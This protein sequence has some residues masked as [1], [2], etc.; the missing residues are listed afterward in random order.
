MA[1]QSDTANVAMGGIG[2][3]VITIIYLVQLAAMVGGFVEWTGSIFL[4][5]LLSIIL[6]FIPI[7]GTIAVIYYATTIWD[8]NV[9]LAI[10]FF[11]FPLALSIFSGSLAVLLALPALIWDYIKKIFK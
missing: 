5:V 6:D 2:C 3:I 7:V 1:N 11:C 8:W 9:I 10:I 4:G